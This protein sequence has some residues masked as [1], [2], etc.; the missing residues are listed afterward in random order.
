MNEPRWLSSDLALAIHE[1]Q[2]AEHGGQGGIRERHLLESALARPQQ[3]FCYGSPPPDLC[4]LAAAYAHGI[5]KSHPF[6]DGNK[7]TAFVVYRVF[8]TWNGII[9]TANKE[10]R[11]LKM[12]A[13]AAGELSEE[14]FAQW[15]REVT[16]GRE[17]GSVNIF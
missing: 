17:E 6:L 13:L 5:A 16:T 3:A 1:R 10:D 4:A 2:L 7:R 14:E 12:L 15:L 9:L 8:L 11:Y